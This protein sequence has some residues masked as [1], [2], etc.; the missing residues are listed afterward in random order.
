MDFDAFISDPHFGHKN[1]IKYCHRPF[2]SIEEMTEKLIE[3]YN[4]T[5]GKN[6][7]VLWLGDCFMGSPTFFA[8]VLSRLNGKKYLILGNHDDIGNHKLVN[9]GFEFVVTKM[10]FSMAGRKIVAN[11][12]DAWNYRSIWDSRYEEKRHHIKPESKEILFH[13]HTHQ[14]SKFL[15]NQVHLGVDAWDMKPARREEVEEIVRNHIP[16]DY[17][18]CEFKKQE[19]LLMEYKQLLKERRE[20]LNQTEIGVHI[21]L[22]FVEERLKDSDFDQ[23]RSLGWENQT[24][25][26]EK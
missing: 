5:V 12:Y 6:D 15:L 8:G 21:N 4:E 17:L 16:E 24:K 25:N 11:H 10:W 13:G 19:E 1:I 2:S 9:C 7:R 14:K 22:E 23:F 26:R 20:A 3:N 18:S